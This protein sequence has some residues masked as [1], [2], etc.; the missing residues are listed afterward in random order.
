[1][2][3][4][5][6]FRNS[7]MENIVV[8]QEIKY[9]KRKYYRKL[10]EYEECKTRPSYNKIGESKPL[11]CKKHCLSD[12]VNVISV[13]CSTEGCNKLPNYNY[14][15]QKRGLFCN[16]HKKENMVDVTHNYCIENNCKKRPSYNYNDNSKAIYCKD[17]CLSGMVNIVTRRCRYKNCQK[18]PNFNFQG[19]K[20]GL[21]CLEHKESNMV[22]IKHKYCIHEECKTRASFNYVNL[23]E[24]LYC[25]L[26]K[27]NNM[28]N[29]IDIKCMFE[30]CNKRPNFNYVGEK[31]GLYCL[32]HKQPDMVDVKHIKCLTHLCTVRA[33]DK[34]DGYCARCFAYLFP[35][36]PNARNYKTKERSVVD[37]VLSRF[38]DFTWVS[39]KR[40][41]EGCSKRRPDL[42]LD[43]GYQIVIVEIDENQ[44]VDYDC[45]CENK[46]VMEISQDLGHRPIVFIRFNPDGYVTKEGKKISSFWNIDGNGVCAINKKNTEKWQ[47]RLDSLCEQIVYWSHPEHK[48][49]K[50]IEN[51]H[52]FYDEIL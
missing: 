31:T 49:D 29:I 24:P 9:K 14:F 6:I 40:I 50:T 20:T 8:C 17:H 22:D 27:M 1:M 28:I 16:E 38:P 4:I 52:L 13:R 15:N 3:N 41:Q 44:H 30:D 39:D 45:S 35:D 21:F 51:V 23:K 18:I 32:Q 37:Y 43:L 47:N 26:H 25:C 7:I 34:Y 36:K 46:R 42:L 19:E 5:L 12:M 33:I 2:R 10:C 48:T 11:Y